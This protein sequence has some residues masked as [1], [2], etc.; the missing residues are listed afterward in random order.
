MGFLQRAAIITRIAYGLAREQGVPVLLRELHRNYV[1]RYL[2]DKTRFLPTSAE[3]EITTHC[4]LNCVMCRKAFRISE[5]YQPRHM[6]MRLLDELLDRL[7]F[8]ELISLCGAGEPILHPQITE[9][10]SKI[11]GSGRKMSIFT[12]GMTMNASLARELVKVPVDEII[13]SI[14][15][16]NQET[17]API[18][19]GGNIDRVFTNLAAVGEVFCLHLRRFSSVFSVPHL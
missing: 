19:V 4:N 1:K 18:R 17:Y 12:N 2:P 6:D 14:D 13:F 5:T 11:V 9:V 16:A 10:A 8:L 15:A 3:F 7:P